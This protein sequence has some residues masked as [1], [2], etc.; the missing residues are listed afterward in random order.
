[1]NKLEMQRLLNQQIQTELI[2]SLGSSSKD[3]YIN[4]LET[5]DSITK[6]NDITQL[7]TTISKLHATAR[8]KI[9]EE[10]FAADFNMQQFHFSTSTSVSVTVWKTEGWDRSDAARISFILK[11]LLSLDSSKF[12]DLLS[13]RNEFA[14]LLK[15]I[16]SMGD[17]KEKCAILKG[18]LLIDP[19]AFLIDIAIDATRTN[20]LKLF[21]SLIIENPYPALFFNDLHLNQVVLKALF[22]GIDL[23]C[24]YGLESRLNKKL[25][26]M[27]RDF[28]QEREAA[29]RSVPSSIRLILSD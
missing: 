8:R 2:R 10:V 17:E 24:C 21:S 7:L 28:Q 6:E 27:C 20:S 11:L 25:K 4:A 1:M 9:G 12:S 22:T 15:K 14:H 19:E 13:S 29:G 26:Q 5:I 3:W 18:L 16:Y 23:H